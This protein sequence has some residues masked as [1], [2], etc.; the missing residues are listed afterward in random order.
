ML[1][2]ET[3]TV[4]QPNFRGSG[5]KGIIQVDIGDTTPVYLWGSVNGTD[6]A[7]IESFSADTIKELTLCPY[8][9]L[10]GANTAGNS[11]VTVGTTR[12]YIQEARG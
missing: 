3:N 12:A 1:T 9:R 8:F 6:Y 7:V 2:L 4:A 11:A 10:S 5:G